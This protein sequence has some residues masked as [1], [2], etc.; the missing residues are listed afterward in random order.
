MKEIL[1]D[2]DGDIFSLPSKEEAVCV[3]TNG[4]IKNNGKAVMGKGIALEADK[5]YNVSTRLAEYLKLYG[6]RA[7]NLG[8]YPNT[9]TNEYFTLFSFPTKENWKDNSK[10][11]LIE[12]SAI[13]IIEMCNKF[14]ISKC[15]LPPVGCSNGNLDYEKQVKPIISSILDERFFVVFR[16][17]NT[18]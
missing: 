9:K 3:T 4:I 2:T 5:N 10:L 13:Q 6:N 14:K 12:K 17:N 8:L 15:Y 11:E 16:T 1:I 7:F 18:F